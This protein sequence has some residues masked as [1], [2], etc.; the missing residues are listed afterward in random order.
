MRTIMVMNAKGGCGKT[1]IASN[2]AVWFADEGY[3]VAIADFDP[4]GSSLDWAEARKDYDGIPQIRAY[5]A[6]RQ[7]NKKLKDVDILIMDVPAGIHGREI[8]QQLKTV[9]TLIVPVLPSPIDIRACK[10]YLGELLRSG[11]INKKQT[12]IGIIA[13][14]VHTNTLV[15]RELK[16]WLKGLSIPFLGALRESKNYLKAAETGLGIFELPPSAAKSDV[17]QWQEILDWLYSAKS[18]PVKPIRKKT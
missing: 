5:N 10:R 18:E 15:Y 3:K 2:I 11:R 6:S 4:Q 1:T 14:R 13:N 7:W 16:D 8:N 17:M 9:D 12:R